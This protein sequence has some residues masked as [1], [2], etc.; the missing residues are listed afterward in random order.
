MGIV[1]FQLIRSLQ[2]MCNP[3][4]HFLL[5]F[6][7]PFDFWFLCLLLGESFSTFC[8]AEEQN[9]SSLIVAQNLHTAHLERMQRPRAQRNNNNTTERKQVRVC[10]KH[11]SSAGETRTGRRR[12]IN[13]TSLFSTGGHCIHCCTC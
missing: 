13:K 7:F 5:C 10:V 9:K 2:L 4:C 3:L 11:L 1:L 6:F 8:G 12:H